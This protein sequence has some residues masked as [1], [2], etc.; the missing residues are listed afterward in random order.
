MTIFESFASVNDE[1][2]CFKKSQLGL[3][4]PVGSKRVKPV[5]K[6]GAAPVVKVMKDASTLGNKENFVSSNYQTPS[7]PIL[8]SNKMIKS[9]ATA[10]FVPYGKQSSS[11]VGSSDMCIVSTVSDLCHSV[12][13]CISN[14]PWDVSR[15]D[16]E[17]YF[18]PFQIKSCHILMDLALDSPAKTM[19]KTLAD[20]YIE[21]ENVGIAMD[22]IKLKNQLLMKNRVISL[23]VSNHQELM[24]RLF[25]QWSYHT[26][27]QKEQY[28]TQSERQAILMVC[29][30]YK[31]HFS[32]KCADRP[33]ELIMSMLEKIQWT[34]AKVKPSERHQKEIFDMYM[35]AVTILK[36]HI[37]KDHHHI[38]ESMLPRFL[39]AGLEC[40]GYN[41]QQKKLIGEQMPTATKPSLDIQPTLDVTQPKDSAVTDVK[42]EDDM[43]VDTP[44][45]SSCVDFGDFEL[46]EKQYQ[47]ETPKQ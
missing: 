39:K 37:Q 26:K 28:I 23:R 20:A 22:C 41:A 1:V 10:N 21:V 47:Q 17:Q 31:Q 5:E 29:K 4:G 30:D 6:T 13:I 33:Y 8:M 14:I 27:S 7:G 34:D 3:Y 9:I 11:K 12:V 36:Q 32:R 44:M 43:D 19:G 16:I 24:R 38:S 42:T 25:P 2:V 40:P 15:R 45:F 18:D 46:E 35:Q